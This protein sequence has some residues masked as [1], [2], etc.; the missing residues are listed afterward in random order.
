[1]LLQNTILARNDADVPGQIAPS[2]CTGPVTSLGNNLI[3]NT[4][5]T[6][7]VQPTDL[8]GDPGLG[9][10]TDNGTPGNGH[11][12]LLSSSQA[13]DAGNNAVCFR[14]DQLGRR[15]VGPCDIGS[16]TLQDKDDHQHEEDLV[17]AVQ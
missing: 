13:I 9:T 3:G 2:D 11:F 14:K 4:G 15:R 16:I 8:T 7:T 6:I 5:Y 17:A 10:F 1:M 12:P